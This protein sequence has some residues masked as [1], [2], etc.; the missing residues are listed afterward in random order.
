MREN[1]LG[2]TRSPSQDRRR[3]LIVLGV[4]VAVSVLAFTLVLTLI[5]EVNRT[6]RSAA[7]ELATLR[8]APV[9]PGAVLM[10]SSA[11]NGAIYSDP[12]A[13]MRY[14]LPMPIAQSCVQVLS[15]YLTAGYR[16]V[17]PGLGSVAATKAWCSQHIRHPEDLF[18]EVDD[19]RTGGTGGADFMASLIAG[20]QVD[21]GP[22][23]V[24]HRS[25]T[26]TLRLDAP[27]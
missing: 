20:T 27:L 10:D 22:V 11:E 7:P 24:V 19:P 12:S 18:V 9:P 6:N 15:A 2:S 26:S 17:H 8:R 14:R 23:S 4:T 1:D 3:F 25:T 16:L 5:H 21:T 13:S